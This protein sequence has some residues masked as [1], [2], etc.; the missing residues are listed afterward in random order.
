MVVGKKKKLDDFAKQKLP[1]EE[2]V[3]PPADSKKL[4]NEP[5]INPPPNEE[6]AEHLPAMEENDHENDEDAVT[7]G[8]GEDLLQKAIASG[9]VTDIKFWQ[10]RKSVV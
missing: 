4:G 7:A 10:D 8:E 5:T 9:D 3:E 1:A 2:T 6:L